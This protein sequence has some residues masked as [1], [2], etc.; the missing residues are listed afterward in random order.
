MPGT[1]TG[2]LAAA[3][4]AGELTLHYQPIVDL[5]T[6]GIAGF[7]ALCRWIHPVPAAEA[8]ALLASGSLVPV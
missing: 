6:G 2:Q 3:V 4:A 8:T 1:L 7:E 5:A